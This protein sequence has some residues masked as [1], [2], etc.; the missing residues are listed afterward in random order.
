MVWESKWLRSFHL[1]H[2]VN[3]CRDGVVKVVDGRMVTTSF[4]ERLRGARAP[5]ERQRA[6]YTIPRGAFECSSGRVDHHYSAIAS[7]PASARAL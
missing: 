3:S 6:L 7:F 1:V 2:R 4:L 5:N